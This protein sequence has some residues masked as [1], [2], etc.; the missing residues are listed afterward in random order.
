[1]SIQYE[2]PR[3]EVIQGNR[4]KKFLLREKAKKACWE[5]VKEDHACSFHVCLDCLV[6]MAQCKDPL[7]SDEKLDSILAQRKEKGFR[8]H[9]CNLS[10]PLLEAMYPD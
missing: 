2:L 3:W 9:K 6:Y 7:L 8:R 1:M 5:Q 4:K 10:H